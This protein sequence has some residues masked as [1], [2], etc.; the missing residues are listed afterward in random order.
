MALKWPLVVVVFL[1]QDKLLPKVLL[2]K[3]QNLLALL[4]RPN[5]CQWPNGTVWLVLCSGLL[6]RRFHGQHADRKRQQVASGGQLWL[7]VSPQCVL[8]SGQQA[9]LFFF[10]IY[11]SNF[12]A[13]RPF[14][15][16][17]NLIFSRALGSCNF[18]P[19]RPKAAQKLAHRLQKKCA[20]LAALLQHLPHSKGAT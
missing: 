2:P 7:T 4:L 15:Q 1:L 16:D 10:F 3:R 5:G 17:R 9:C 11:L 18:F 19:S 14:C 20:E 13:V 8:V 6:A 12:F